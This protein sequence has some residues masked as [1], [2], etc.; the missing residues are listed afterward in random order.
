[1]KNKKI[2]KEIDNRKD[3]IESFMCIRQVVSEEAGKNTDFNHLDQNYE[4]EAEKN[5]KISIIMVT[6]KSVIHFHHFPQ[7]QKALEVRTYHHNTPRALGMLD[8][9]KMTVELVDWKETKKFT[10]YYLFDSSQKPL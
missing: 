5:L 1:L 7:T 9:Q 6:E 10:Q 3:F 4:L 8:V 2:V